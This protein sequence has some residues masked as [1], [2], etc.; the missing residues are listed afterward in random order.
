VGRCAL[1]GR[2]NVGKSTLLNALV[3]QKLAITAERPGTTR[4]RI[5]G[6]YRSDETQTQITFV[7]T[8]GMHRPRNALGKVLVEET[9]SGV[10]DSD[11]VLLITDGPPKNT[12]AYEIPDGDRPVLA[13]SAGHPTI[14]AINKV[15]LLRDKRAILSVIERYRRQRDFNAIVPISAVERTNLEAL[16]AEIR[17]TLPG[18]KLSP[19]D[20]VTDRPVRFFAS[21]LIR[22]AAIRN[23]RKEVPHGVA[24]VI[25][26]FSD[27]DERTTIFATL[28]VERPSHKK[29]VI[30]ARGARIKTIGTEARTA[31]EEL[32]GRSVVLK[33][34]VKVE[35]DWT[36]DPA[37]ARCLT[38]EL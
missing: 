17:R 27:V 34:W 16:I 21:E 37:R 32:L 11:V 8:P 13:L 19:T 1:V 28:V 10:S 14:L 35:P 5:A 25:D 12:Q 3:G 33:I 30:G 4:N 29:I 15:D 38:R 6:I 9:R 31:I 36:F 20:D 22:E 24:V 26:E 23:T 18:G 2:A 7:D